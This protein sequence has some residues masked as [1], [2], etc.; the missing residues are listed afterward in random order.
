[1][2]RMILCVAC[3]LAM[4]SAH[5][6]N[7]V[8]AWGAAPDSDGPSLHRQSVR[9]Q[10]RISAS[11][12]RVRIRL[13]NAYGNGA[14]TLGPVQ[15][16]R[17]GGAPRPVLFDGR[18]NV[19]IPKGEDVLSDPLELA[20]AP[21]DLL[22][23]SIYVEDGAATLHS[24]ARHSA[25]ISGAPPTSSDSRYFLSEVQ[26]DAAPGARAIV[27]VGDSI[28]DGDGSTPNRNARWPDALAS[29]LHGTSI[30][31]V[32]SGISGNRLLNDGPVG[33]SMLQRV[34]RDAF[35][36]P[37]V[38]WLVLEAG[39]NDIGLADETGIPG[40][41]VTADA[42]IAGM[43]QVIAQA[44]ARGIKV[45]GATLTP[46]GGAQQPLRHNAQAEAKRLAVNAW[47]RGSRSFDRVLDFDAAVRDPGDR[48]R[49][50]PALDSG[51]HV[52]PNDAGY[53]ALAA[54][55]P[56]RFFQR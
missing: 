53:R 21:L 26:V 52:H 45:W 48:T 43:Q 4:T 24:D 3:A 13:S 16:G 54:A 32:N 28:S 18:P 27:V 14:L 55:V 30:A 35:D 12:T 47:I 50:L 8:A 46:Y 40:G 5:A 51:D 39:L 9:Q 20:L 25:L 6:A 38:K 41:P 10:L 7:W 1:M 44:H 22:D 17:A 19:T 23:V 15:L 42:I 34:Q 2:H 11:G 37:G 31:V 49:I 56:L 29:R 36:K 33:S